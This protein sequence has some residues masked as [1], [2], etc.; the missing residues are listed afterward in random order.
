MLQHDQL[1]GQL[2]YV[3]LSSFPRPKPH[4]LC[5]GGEAGNGA[6][7]GATS[8]QPA[9]GHKRSSGRAQGRTRSCRMPRA[10]LPA[11]PIACRV[12]AICQKV[13]HQSPNYNG[14]EVCSKGFHFN[15]HNDP[16]VVS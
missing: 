2:K 9:K 11:L 4:T 1:L 14:P 8:Q 10:S 16:K 7:E 5:N 6:G 12:G 13:H 15:D 3:L